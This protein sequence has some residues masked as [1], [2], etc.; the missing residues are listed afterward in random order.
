MGQAPPIIRLTW[1]TATPIWADRWPLPQEKLS[2][3]HNLVQEQ[4]QQNHI[5]VSFSPWNTPVFVIP[6]KSG[7]WRLLQ[8]LR[9]I[10]AVMQSVGAL[11]PGMPTPTMIPETWQILIID[12]KDCFFAI[13]LHPD[14]RE[15]FAFSVPSLNKQEPYKR[16]QWT[17]LPQGMKNSP[18][19]CQYF[20]AWALAPLRCMYPAWIIYHYMDDIL[21][22]AKE[23]PQDAISFFK[24]ALA[25][26]GLQVSGNKIQ[27][28]PAYKYLGLT[29]TN[30]IVRP[31][32]LRLH[33]VGNT[34][35]DVQKWTGDLQW[36]CSYCGI[37]TEDSAPLLQLLKGGG[38]GDNP[39]R[40]LIK[41][42]EKA[43]WVIEEKISTTYTNRRVEN[44]G[45]RLAVLNS[46]Y[47]LA[48]NP[49]RAEG[50]KT[51]AGFGSPS[52][53]IFAERTM[54]TSAVLGSCSPWRARPAPGTAPR[55]PGC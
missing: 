34:L 38:G 29:I 22:A 2:H 6:K 53:H 47:R 41:E 1:L 33:T 12:L 39:P 4:L 44:V 43:L 19:I 20:V 36:V 26:A 32:K 35:H 8:D 40:K 15:K 25:R 9:A 42:Q 52:P 31:Q 28:Q 45:M 7:K 55:L 14:D 10:N 37:T 24:H 16:S 3:L 11:Q 23:L 51:F 49:T 46:D 17:V 27:I 54:K 18:T 30:A 21:F 5:E 50:S 48:A 13:P